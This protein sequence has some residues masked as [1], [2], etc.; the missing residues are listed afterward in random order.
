LPRYYAL[1]EYDGSAYYG[2]QRQREG[3]PTIQA[4]LESAL[5]HV[6]HRPIA[7]TGAGRTDSGVHALGQVITFN[8]EWQ[9]GSEALQRALNANLPADIAIL[10][11]NEVSSTFHPRFDA[12][13]RTY[14]YYVYNA[15]VRSPLRQQRSWHVLRPLD[16]KGMNQAAAHL[17]GVHDFATFGQPPQGENSVR[18]VFTA[19]WQGPK[20]E[21][22]VFSITANAFLYRM[23]R[24]LVGSLKLVG[25]GAWTVEDFVAALQA[26]DRSRSGAPAPAHGLY[27]V[28]VAYDSEEMA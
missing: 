5:G 14:A 25:E 15:A 20:D 9:H 18:E 17:I 24:S 10:Q 19:G 1:V 8:V 28:S 3:Q 2:F 23:V 27:L 7:I 6:G 22:L 11:L 4:E 13:R 12:R 16:V 21:L 26:R